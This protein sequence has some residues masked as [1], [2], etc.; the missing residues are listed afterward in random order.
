MIPKLQDW[1]LHGTD[2]GG[3]LQA[4]GVVPKRVG[5]WAGWLAADGSRP[6]RHRL[7]VV[8]SGGATRGAF[9]VGVIDVLARQ[10]IVPELLVGTSVGAINAAYWAFHPGPEVGP[11]LLGVWRD[12]GRA[13]VLPDRPLR[14]VGNLIGSRLRERGS[15]A[16]ILQRELPEAGATI[17]SARL[18]LHIVAC[19]LHTG[20]AVDFDHGPALPALLASAAVPGIFPPVIIAGD[21]YVDGGVVA[22][23]PIE[24]ARRAGATDVLAIDLIGGSSWVPSGGFGVLER[25]VDISLANQTERELESW[26][27]S[28]RV[29]LL[30]LRYDLAPG[31]GDFR[32]TLALYRQGQLAAQRF[33]AE[34]WAGGGKVRPGLVEFETPEMVAT[35]VPHGRPRL[36]SAWRSWR[37]RTGS[38][39]PAKPTMN[40]A[41]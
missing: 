27:G 30:R 22:N 29:A 21:P 41:T 9:Q 18:P 3:L 13:R 1:P 17:E 20:V 38:A 36:G 33:L 26:Q 25:V 11:H 31:F 37:H 4:F 14:V 7:A 6:P 8:L 19:N 12:A 40:P 24:V 23:C 35:V 15:L 34:Q 5:S 32:H 39:R 28:L 2:R 16:R 10:G